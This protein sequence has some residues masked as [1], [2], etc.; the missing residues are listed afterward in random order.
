MTSWKRR[1]AHRLFDQLTRNQPLGTVRNVAPKASA[2]PVVAAA[3][4]PV[5]QT[6][7]AETGAWTPPPASGN[8]HP[9]ESHGHDH[10]Q[11]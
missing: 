10:Q 1:P 4:D 2:R 9:T 6:R 3:P 5:I 8:S 11:A 7:Q